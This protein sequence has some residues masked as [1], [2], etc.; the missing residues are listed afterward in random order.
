[1]GSM[2]EK[3]SD[4]VPQFYYD[5]IARVT[6]GAIACIF[7]WA[8]FRE[9]VLW[10]NEFGA[11]GVLVT[12]FVVSYFFGLIFDLSSELLLSRIACIW[13]KCSTEHQLNWWSDSALWSKLVKLQKTGSPWVR[14]Q[15]PV[16]TKMMAERSLLR[17][18]IFELILIAP[19][20]YL[21]NCRLQETVVTDIQRAVPITAV[22]FLPFVILAF[23]SLNRCLK[24]R[25]KEVTAR[26]N[27]KP[28]KR[29]N[30]TE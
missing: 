24:Q 27:A 1:M 6:P 19:T 29:T 14:S 10:P 7:L 12:A 13:N 18:A 17:G 4:I 25:I 20:F 23:I 15:L 26:N 3:L 21:L 22:L 11:A 2:M 16:L 9:Y 8:W 5:L 28:N 30:R